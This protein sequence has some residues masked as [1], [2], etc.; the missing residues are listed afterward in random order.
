MSDLRKMEDSGG[1]M[2]K[3]GPRLELSSAGGN[4]FCSPG[5]SEDTGEI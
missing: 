5:A 3:R 1:R 4:V 2:V